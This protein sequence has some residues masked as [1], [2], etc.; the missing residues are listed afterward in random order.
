MKRV[1]LVCGSFAPREGGAERQ[2]RAVLAGLSRS[3]YECHVVTQR[4]PDSPKSESID[5]IS[6]HRVGSFSAFNVHPRVGMV[7]YLLAAL[8]ASL[9]LRPGHIVSLQVGA[10]S[11]A[12][13][14]V[15]RLVRC[16][17]TVRLTGGGSARFRSEAFARS[18]T[19]NGRLVTSLVLNRRKAVLVAP[20]RHLIADFEE[21][22]PHLRAS[23]RVVPNGVPV[24]PQP[25][26]TRRRT[27]VVW[28]SR[29]GSEQT[30]SLFL[31]VARRCDSVPF[32]VIGTEIRGVAPPNVE[33]L[34][35]V[36]QP[37]RAM[38]EARVLLNTSPYEGSPNVALQALATGCRVVGR[39]NAGMRELR[40]RYGE[41]VRLVAD[42]DAESLAEEV[43]RA[44]A[45]ESLSP[46]PVV[47][48]DDAR[49]QWQSLLEGDLR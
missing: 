31:Q 28:Y 2:M 48:T 38:W 5:G 46:A 37:M 15:S 21:C 47:T 8:G 12:G 25:P 36:D 41:A 13:S 11:L 40:E 43:R 17:H 24:L 3:G 22:F 9:R 39:D 32:R 4:L 14:V 45:A 23:R 1:V 30:E 18:A 7:A 26:P 42:G 19:L 20:A 6:V 33:Q 49:G 29:R 16:P 44:V 10:A 27:G 35:W 34:G